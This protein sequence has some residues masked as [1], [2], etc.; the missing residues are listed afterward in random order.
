MHKKN[1]QNGMW[2]TREHVLEM[3]TLFTNGGAGVVIREESER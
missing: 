2:W 1:V 3:L